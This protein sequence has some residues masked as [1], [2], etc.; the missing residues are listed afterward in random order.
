MRAKYNQKLRLNYALQ[1]VLRP[2][3]TIAPAES[4]PGPQ[5]VIDALIENLIRVNS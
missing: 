2:Q 1:W 5:S 4:G 3:C